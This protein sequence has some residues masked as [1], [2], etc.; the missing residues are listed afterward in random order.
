MLAPIRFVLN[1][2]R[3]FRTMPRTVFLLLSAL[4]GGAASLAVSGPLP[5]DVAVTIALQ[6]AFGPAPQWAEWLTDTA[7]PP[8]VLATIAVGAAMAGLATGWRGA[9]SIPIAFGLAWLIEK[10][11]RAIIFA[12]RPTSDLVAVA[13]ASSSSGLPSTFG[14][15]YGSIFGA[16]L[17]EAASGRIALAVRT[18]AAAVI[19]TGAS[20]RIVLGGHWTGQMLV[21]ILLGL[22]AASTALALTNLERGRERTNSR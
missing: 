13:S 5:G 11:L 7:K 15:V 22:A 12:P 19:V 2:G 4:I 10:A 9:V 16:V 3:S 14:L 6:S 1:A 18:L 20:A 21:S 17:L 8:M